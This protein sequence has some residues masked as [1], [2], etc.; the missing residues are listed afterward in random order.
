[1][2]GTGVSAKGGECCVCE[3]QPADAGSLVCDHAF[4]HDCFARY[5]HGSLDAL[6][7]RLR[8]CVCSTRS[9]L[10][11]ETRSE[12]VVLSFGRDLPP[13][14]RQPTGL[15]V[16]RHGGDV[17][18][19]DRAS[20]RILVFD[21]HGR[22]NTDFAY[23]YDTLPMT[24]LAI[25]DDDSIVVPSRERG[26]RC[27]SF[28]T[29]DGAFLR[30]TYLDAAAMIQAVAVMPGNWLVAADSANNCVHI[31]DERRRLIRSVN[32]D[33]RTDDAHQ[34]RPAGVA[35][36]SV[37]EI[38]VSDTANDCIRVLDADAKWLFSVGRQGERPAQFKR[39]LG[40]AVDADDNILV[41]DSQNNRVQKLS[42][43]GKF[44]HYVVRY[45]RGSHVYMSPIDV[46]SLADG[47][48]AVLMSGVRFPEIGEVRVYAAV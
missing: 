14:L 24:G 44:R 8:C 32:V 29:L 7:T 5:V 11:T 48:V 25:T 40:V 15:A 36:N 45:N 42:A 31:I 37:G 34:P 38:I 47:R 16:R 1:M 19:V 46:A 27:L 10:A 12:N 41:A 23:V 13:R 2:R 33:Q 3:C 35:V 30:S 4:C 39:P 43:T 18:I 9:R 22:I 17:A 26:Y 6:R 20:R 21:A 28:Y